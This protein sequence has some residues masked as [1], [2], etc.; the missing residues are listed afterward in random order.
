M[1]ALLHGRI[2]IWVRVLQFRL[3][4]YYYYYYYITDHQHAACMPTWFHG[5][6]LMQN[7]LNYFPCN[8]IFRAYITC[9]VESH[10]KKYVQWHRSDRHFIQTN[11]TPT[12][13]LDAYD[14]VIYYFSRDPTLWLLKR[15]FPRHN[16]GL[17]ASENLQTNAA[18]TFQSVDLGPYTVKS[19]TEV[20]VN[21]RLFRCG[22]ARR[23][24]KIH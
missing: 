3:K 11:A 19:L 1:Y 20:R 16:T 17:Y 21:S 9:R 8:V 7:S 12:P 15:K 10:T 13:T 24:R 5:T 18:D 2:Q 14:S 6:F 23:N 22:F 4:Y